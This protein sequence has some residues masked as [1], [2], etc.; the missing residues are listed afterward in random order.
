MTIKAI[1]DFLG[2]KTYANPWLVRESSSGYNMLTIEFLWVKKSGTPLS[3]CYRYVLTKE[4]WT[5]V[6]GE[7]TTVGRKDVA[8]K[9]GAA[10][11]FSKLEQ[12]ADSFLAGVVVNRKPLPAIMLPGSKVPDEA[13]D[14]EERPQLRLDD[15]VTPQTIQNLSFQ[16]KDL[17]V[18]LQV[19][20]ITDRSALS[21]LEE[22]RKYMTILES[23]AKF[24]PSKYASFS[25]YNLDRFNKSAKGTEEKK[26]APAASA[27]I[28]SED[29]VLNKI[30]K[31]YAGRRTKAD[32]AEFDTEDDALFAYSE[33][34]ALC[35]CSEPAS[36]GGKF[37]ITGLNVPVKKLRASRASMN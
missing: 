14:D 18:K 28:S 5:R 12:Y 37:V 33:L 31:Q 19:Q 34:E 1:S 21:H 4:G 9:V 26:A 7:S 35:Q 24:T 30:I 10:E 23:F 3:E 29:E 27:P 2:V 32:T 6:F 16:L 11:I 17:I 15:L 20:S 8:K 13:K 22:A 36:A 25:K